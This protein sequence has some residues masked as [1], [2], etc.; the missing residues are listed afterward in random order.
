MEPILPYWGL[1]L[2]LIANLLLFFSLKQELHTQDRRHRQ[3]MESLDAFLKAA[4]EQEP[5][6]EPTQSP[7]RPPL[8]PGFNLNRRVLAMRMLRRGEDATHIAAALG[9]TDREV[10]LLI[11]VQK[12]TA[13]SS[14]AGPR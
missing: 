13:E 11:R 9:V 6:A 10:E 1:A 4:A 14:I 7:P 5:L 12:T 3:K 8:G 2:G